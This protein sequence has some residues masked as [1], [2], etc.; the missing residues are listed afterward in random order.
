MANGLT[1]TRRTGFSEASSLLP[2][3]KEPPGS[4][5]MMGSRTAPVAGAPCRAA[6]FSAGA[7][8]GAGLD[9]GWVLAV[10]AGDGAPCNC[11]EVGADANCCRLGN[12]Y[13][14]AATAIPTQARLISKTNKV[15]RRLRLLNAVGSGSTR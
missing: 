11:G 15:S 2:I 7:A 12:Q 1:V 13:Q 3:T 6:C 4:V 5:F 14:T 10:S 8:E 9:C